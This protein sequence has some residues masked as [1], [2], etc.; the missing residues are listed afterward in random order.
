MFTGT[1]FTVTALRLDTPR[2]HD[3]PRPERFM[4]PYSLQVW[5][6]EL[7]WLGAEV[8]ARTRVRRVIYMSLLAPLRGGGDRRHTPTGR[9]TQV[10]PAARK[11]SQSG[12][13][14]SSYS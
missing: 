9:R 8:R 6:D 10:N 14:K 3:F 12:E 13:I 5:Q 1:H 4:V 2:L 7:V 11:A